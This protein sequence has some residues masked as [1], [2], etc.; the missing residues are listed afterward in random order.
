MPMEVL[1]IILSSSIIAELW[2]FDTNVCPEHKAVVPL[3]IL[4]L[5]F[6]AHMTLSKFSIYISYCLVTIV[7]IRISSCEQSGLLFIKLKK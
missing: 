4:H 7:L 2:I 6:I 5:I 1:L 3:T